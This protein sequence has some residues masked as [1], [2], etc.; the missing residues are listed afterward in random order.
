MATPKS[1]RELELIQECRVL[2][3]KNPHLKKRKLNNIKDLDK[4]LYYIKVW[5]ITESQPI[6]KLKNFENRCWRCSGGYHLDHIYPI[7]MGFYN[8]ISPEIIGNI[9]NLRFIPIKDNLSKGYKIT[10]ES[11]E[12]LRKFKRKGDIY[13]KRNKK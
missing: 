2:I 8:K 13:K 12:V 3:R 11:H 4:R 10:E 1:K 9:K 5:A 6:F 7:S